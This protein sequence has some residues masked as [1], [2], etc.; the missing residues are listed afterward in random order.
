M[1]TN[2]KT[3]LAVRR[4]VFPDFEE[5]RDLLRFDTRWPFAFPARA[6]RMA[7]RE[8]PAIDMFERDGNVVVKAEMPGI[9]PAKIDVTV[10]SGE[11]RMSGERKEEHE[12]KEEQYYRSERTFGH[13]FRA[14]TLPEGCDT[15]HIAATARDGVLEVV[16]PKKQT[17]VT[18]KVEVKPA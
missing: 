18:H 10:V 1:A 16:I 11:L 4:P 3:E 13:I 12:V 9:D 6:L 14:L 15:E 2:G 8:L 5:L 7:E 17:A